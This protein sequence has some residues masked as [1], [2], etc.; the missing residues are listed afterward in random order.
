MLDY[1]AALAQLLDSHDCTQAV[2]T[3]P[4]SAAA[5]R[6]LAEPLSARYP[7]PMFDN[8]AMD[9]YAVCDPEGRLKTFSVVS[10]TQAGEVPA[11]AL[12]AGE[13]VRIFTGA[14]VPAGATAVVMQEHAECSDGLLH[15]AEP[16]KAGANIRY[17]AEEIEAGQA[18]LPQGARLSAAALGLAASQ[19]YAELKV[20][21]PLKAVV[22]SSG[23][24][25]AEP[26]QPLSDGHIYDANR[27]QLL[28]WLAAQGIETADGGILSDDLAATETALAGAAQRA[29]IIITSGGASVGEADYLKQAVEN[30]GTLAVHT[31]AVKPGKPFGWGHIGTAKVFVLPGNPVAAFVT[32]QILLLPVLAKLAGK[33]APYT[34]PQIAARAAFS[35]RKAI[36]RREFLRVTHRIADD[37]TTVAELLPNQGSAMLATCTAA[38]ALCEIPAG[39]T[40]SEGGRVLLYLLP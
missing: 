6:I 4:L 25:L 33:A 35:T 24:E 30:L 5:N 26:G 7:S 32:A 20:F 29:D 12:Q 2:E 22:F 38:T 19:G 16:A 40:V 3:L 28:A 17:R 14:P 31:L 1:H 37:G 13:A 10:R 8:S 9:G 11:A 36:K 34:L 27:Y 18:L 23:N 15:L 39:E 21:K